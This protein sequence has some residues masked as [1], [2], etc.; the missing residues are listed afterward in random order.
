MNNN[1]TPAPSQEDK[2]AVSEMIV[3]YFL[4]FLEDGNNH[5]GSITEQPEAQPFLDALQV[6]CPQADRHSPLAKMLLVFAGGVDA[7]LEICQKIDRA[8]GEGAQG[9]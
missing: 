3:Q 1:Q 7:G 8:A 4:A 9:K 6:V 5:P 2:A